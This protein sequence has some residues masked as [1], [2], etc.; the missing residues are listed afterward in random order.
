[1]HH[2]SNNSGLSSLI[3][4]EGKLDELS[5]DIESM[6][7]TY[8]RIGQL[9]SRRPDLLPLNYLDAL[10]KVG[11]DN[12]GL[13]NT[14]L[15]KA[16]IDAIIEKEF[17][18]KTSHIFS[19]FEYTAISSSV[20]SQ[21]HLATQ[22]SGKRV[23]LKIMRPSILEDVTEEL[24]ELS[25][26]VDFIDQAKSNK[27]FDYKL[28][29][30]ELQK[31]IFS[32]LDFRK[33]V[34]NLKHLKES[35]AFLDQIVV[36]E[37]VKHL[38]TSKIITSEFI[39][40]TQLG[41]T[42]FSGL[43][44]GER[45]NLAGQVFQA[46]LHQ[47][48]IDGFVHGSFKIDNVFLTNSG[49]IALLDLG[50]ATHISKRVQECILKLLLA[51]NE[52]RGDTVAT[53]LTQLGVTKENF[54]EMSF[55]NIIEDLVMLHQ[56]S[57]EDRLEMARVFTGIGQAVVKFGIT[58]PA[59]LTVFSNTLMRVDKISD[60]IDPTFDSRKFL[61]KNVSSIVRDNAIKS[62]SAAHL[63]EGILESV[64][65]LEKM[66]SKISKI[67][68]SA[69]ENQFKITVDAIDERVLISG[70]QKIANRITAG[71]ILAALIMGA[72]QLMQVQTSFQIWGYPGLAILCFLAAAL[73]GF[74][75][76]IEV[77]ISDSLE[78]RK[79]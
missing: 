63:F 26:I 42:N 41:S 11:I 2:D 50:K 21:T 28:I 14:K 69:A 34:L 75:L 45:N 54:D 30:D 58:L 47:F 8:T 13:E 60:M 35:L 32:E 18:R 9:L 77:L 49:S 39:D 59:E 72:A 12:S 71:L 61:K 1:M 43:L 16:E 6:G 38:C 73:C 27:Q 68:D 79:S 48:L 15:E 56:T 55:R 25:Q 31:T 76:V 57:S 70:F 17:G 52:G 36:P 10:Q 74:A 19:N 67:L 40:G 23:I 3:A 64:H 7:P 62:F 33:E 24:G 20:F 51:L 37:P 29:F 4:G 46:F 78:R 65:L 5:R 44:S 22:L 53:I 66:P